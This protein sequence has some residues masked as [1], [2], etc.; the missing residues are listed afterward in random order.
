[1]SKT[2]TAADAHRLLDEAQSI[3]RNLP[4]PRVLHLNH[5]MCLPFLGDRRTDL[6]E[7]DRYREYAKRDMAHRL[8]EELIRSGAVEFRE[9]LVDD[10]GRMVKALRIG[11]KIKLA[12]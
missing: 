4:E 6:T 10:F 3:L 9:E 5:E 11:A 8:A 7:L 12:A 2:K 1:M